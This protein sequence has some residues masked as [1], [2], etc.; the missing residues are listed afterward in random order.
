MRRPRG[1]RPT[2]GANGDELYY[3][4]PDGMFMVATLVED[5]TGLNVERAPL[6]VA[7][8]LPFDVRTHI[9]VVDDG[10]TFIFNE[11]A[12]TVP[13]VI[14]VIRNWTSLLQ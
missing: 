3:V 10:Q 8:R 13:R 12:E 7:P 14:T 4:R 2:W 5:A 11:V 9:A 1:G 6:F